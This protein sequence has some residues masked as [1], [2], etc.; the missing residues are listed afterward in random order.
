MSV[1]QLVYLN[2]LTLVNGVREEI[3]RESYKIKFELY[4]RN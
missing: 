2:F 3:D 1:E 4:F